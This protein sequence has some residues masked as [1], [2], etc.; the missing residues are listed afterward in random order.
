MTIRFHG[1]TKDVAEIIL[2]RGFKKGTHFAKHLEDALVMGGKYIFWVYFEEDP[3][4]YWEYISD[5]KTPSSRILLLRKY[6]TSRLYQNDKLA[7]R[8]RHECNIE[9]HGNEIKH[10]KVCRGKGEIH[11][12]EWDESRVLAR[13][14]VCSNCRGFGCTRKDGSLCNGEKR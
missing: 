8:I 9:Y 4:K 3:T 10:C 11:D 7:E 1:T 13:T 2:K 6:A 5:K 14:V 12:R